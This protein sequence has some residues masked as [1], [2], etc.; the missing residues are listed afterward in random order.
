LLKTEAD[1][2]RAMGGGVNTGPSLNGGGAGGGSG[3]SGEGLGK[4]SIFGTGV[5]GA[6]RAF[7]MAGAAGLAANV[8][9][10]ALKAGIDVATEALKIFGSFV[11]NDVVK[12][13]LQREVTAQQVA[14]ASMGQ[15]TAP[16]ILRQTRE[17]SIKHNV[18]E[19]EIMSGQKQFQGIT[20][21]PT[22]GFDIADTIASISKARGASMDDLYKLAA[23]IYSAGD[24]SESIGNK[25]RKIVAQGDIGGIPIQ[26]LAHLGTRFSTLTAAMGGTS[27]EKVNQAN[28]LLQS[29][30]F[31]TPE[32]TMR[33]AEAL[34]R[35]VE[36]GKLNGV[37]GITKGKEGMEITDIA[38]VIADI[39]AKSK[40]DVGRY[41]KNN[42]LGA[43]A[44]QL[45][46]AHKSTYDFALQD[47]I[48][49]GKKEAQARKD[50]ADAVKHHIDE[51][52]KATMTE[53]SLREEEA[54]VL[55]ASEERFELVLK[56]LSAGIIESG[57]MDAITDMAEV[58]ANNGADIE[59]AGELIVG[60]MIEVGKLIFAIFKKIANVVLGS[61]GVDTLDEA[62]EIIK[63]KN[64]IKQE[65][66]QH[67]RDEKKRKREEAEYNTKYL[68]APPGTMAPPGT[69]IGPPLPP[70]AETGGFY[71]DEFGNKVDPAKNDAEGPT[72]ADS[73]DA[74][75][76]KN[77]EVADSMDALNEKNE[78]AADS[79]NVLNKKNEEA[80]DSMDTLTK[81]INDLINKISDL[82]AALVGLNRLKD[83][84]NL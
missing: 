4:F 17:L 50:A 67:E 70:K 81:K 66:R 37:K 51:I 53:A 9:L 40:G 21:Q 82:A 54:K 68:Q 19:E 27:E 79:M 45:L 34:V 47:S 59:A 12:P 61:V 69:F 20:G 84:L 80:A 10:Q 26:E 38:T 25:L 76:E 77:E 15:L 14:N 78:E 58:L 74:L 22:L 64:K 35:D 75:N 55:R 31:G 43:P 83:L 7:S 33:G 71:V 11:L 36:E 6:A 3:L 30:R 65:L 63:N 48:R 1:L 18:S 2:R 5:M 44:M 72:T 73:T 41:A 23:G 8:A 39:F 56:Q 13:Q 52:N 62:L 60:S 32:K 24:T 29:S 49:N 57:L 42:K 16:E 28:L 46:E